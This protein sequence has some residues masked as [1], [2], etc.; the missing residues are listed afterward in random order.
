M[1]K[2][3]NNV[4]ELKWSFEYVHIECQK[5]FKQLFLE[6]RGISKK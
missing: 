4:F 6:P 5:L 1:S 2:E 3:N